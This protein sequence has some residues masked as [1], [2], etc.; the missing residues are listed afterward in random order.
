MQPM[1]D[2]AARREFLD[3]SIAETKVEYFGEYQPGNGLSPDELYKLGVLGRSF[4]K[5]ELY[6]NQVIDDFPESEYAPK[7]MFTLANLYMDEFSDQRNARN[8]LYQLITRYPDCDMFDDAKYMLDN[9][10]KRNLSKP[11][12]IEELRQNAE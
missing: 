10:G 3:K 1:L 12:P 8:L 5:Q 9:L 2:A 11:A 7:A 4:Q 6:L